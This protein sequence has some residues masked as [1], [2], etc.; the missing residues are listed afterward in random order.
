[1]ECHQVL[2]S[3]DQVR[4]QYALGVN[5]L[6]QLMYY[7]HPRLLIELVNK[8]QKWDKGGTL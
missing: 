5:H 2:F 6:V 3:V 1:M 8:V 7:V 4:I